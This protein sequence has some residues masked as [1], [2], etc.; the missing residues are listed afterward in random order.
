MNAIGFTS[1]DDVNV[2][3][4]TV[5][6]GF[7]SPRFASY[8]GNANIKSNFVVLYFVCGTLLTL[9]LLD[10]NVEHSQLYLLLELSRSNHTAIDDIRLYNVSFNDLVIVGISQRSYPSL[11][12]LTI[13]SNVVKTII[14]V[15]HIV[16]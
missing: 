9:G 14:V 4:I 2:N 15:R 3:N 5:K 10:I 11:Q 12:N 6:Q 8:I 16:C 1:I 7:T 13:S